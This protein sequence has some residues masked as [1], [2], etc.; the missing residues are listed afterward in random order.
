MLTSTG[1]ELERRSVNVGGVLVVHFSTLLYRVWR[2]LRVEH[3]LGEGVSL[4][5][6]EQGR[7]KWLRIRMAS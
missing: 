6:Q 7:V 4:L 3:D 5:Y 1:I 2:K